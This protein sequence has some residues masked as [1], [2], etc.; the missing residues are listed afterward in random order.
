[1]RTRPIFYTGLFL[2]LLALGAILFSGG[3][4][5]S[6]LSLASS[7]IA[8][9]TKTPVFFLASE[10]ADFRLGERMHIEAKLRSEVAINALA[11]S[12][13]IPPEFFTI[14]SI[15]KEGSLIDLWTE[16]TTINEASGTIRWSGGSIAEGG[17][18]GVAPLLTIT[19]R[20]LRTGTTTIL[21][22]STEIYAHDGTG[23]PLA[24]EARALPL[25]IE[26]A[27]ISQTS[28]SSASNTSPLS[29]DLNNDGRVSIADASIMLVQL[30]SDYSARY[31]LN[32][33]G[34]INLADFAIVLAAR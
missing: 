18:V 30:F 15:S 9:D 27:D 1:M 6:L 7:S 10:H 5:T 20:A 23:Q 8:I 21:F 26:P 12:L 22:D 14:E 11:A 33:D 24:H 2:G 28:T 34:A 25:S 19:L 4:H 32:R 16:E 31:D 29:A 17:F 3:R 13:Y